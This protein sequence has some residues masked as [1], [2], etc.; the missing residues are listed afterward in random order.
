MADTSHIPI[1][2]RVV[3]M[4]ITDYRFTMGSTEYG[5]YFTH[6]DW[7]SSGLDGH[8]GLSFYDGKYRIWQILHTFRL[9]LEWS[10]WALWI[11][12][13]RWE[14]ENMA[15][16]SHIPI[17]FRVVWMGITVSREYGKDTSHIRIGSWAVWMGI[18][19]YRFMMG[20][21]EYFHLHCVTVVLKQKIPSNKML[22]NLE[23]L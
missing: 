22:I 7:F 3:W 5:R 13:L 6:S 19:D 1:G 8:Y 4:G 2:S 17:G 16:T 12:V 15:D 20:S 14:V 11:I 18:M 21:T 9:V 10:G 23:R